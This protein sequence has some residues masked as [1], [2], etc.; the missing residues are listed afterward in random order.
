MPVYFWN[1]P[2]EL[3][4]VKKF[5][6][7]DK[8][9]KFIQQEHSFNSRLKIIAVNAKFSVMSG[10]KQKRLEKQLDTSVNKFCCANRFSLL[11]H[12]AHGCDM[13]GSFAKTYKSNQMLHLVFLG[14]KSSKTSSNREVSKN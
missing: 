5:L 12:Y 2:T 9:A 7:I 1:N 8:W 3:H 13:Q 14:P 11:E 4:V 6:F 10:K